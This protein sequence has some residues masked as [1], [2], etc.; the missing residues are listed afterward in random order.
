MDFNE[1]A[2]LFAW[3][4]GSLHIAHNIRIHVLELE[5]W[6]ARARICFVLNENKHSTRFRRF[7]T[8]THGNENSAAYCC[9]IILSQRTTDGIL[10][11]HK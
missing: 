1:N 7:A 11:I 10:L 5:C 4:T 3:P 9:A 2:A 6:W 8:R